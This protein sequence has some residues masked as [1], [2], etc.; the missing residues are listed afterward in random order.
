MKNHSAS[1]IRWLV[2]ALFIALAAPGR[3]GSIANNLLVHLSFDGNLADDSGS[4]NNGNALGKP[5]FAAGKIGSALSYTTLANGGS[6]NYVSLPATLKFG[7]TTNFTVAFWVNFT[8]NS[9]DLPFVANMDWSSAA[10]PGWAIAMQDNGSWQWNLSGG[11][12]ASS[13]VSYLDT[14]YLRDGNWHHLAVSFNRQANASAYVDGN[15]VNQTP[16]SASTGTI[17]TGF[18]INVGQDGTGAYTDE[19]TAQ[20][21]NAHLDDLGIWSRELSPIE[22]G[23][24]YLQGLNGVNITAIPD[25]A[26]PFLYQL[27]P[28]SASTNA[29][30]AGT[31]FASIEDGYLNAINT[32]SIQLSLD[33]VQAAASVQY[34]NGITTL[35]YQPP[36]LLAPLTSHFYSLAFSDNN[37]PP[38][39]YTTS[40]HF[41]VA[42]Y[43][44]LVL[45]NPVYLETFDEVQPGALPAGWSTQNYSDSDPNNPGSSLYDPQDATY[46]NWVV[47]SRSIV[48][49]LESAGTWEANSRLEVA[50]LQVVNGVLLTNLIET[51][52]IYAESDTRVGAAIQYLFSPDYNLTGLSNLFISYRS[53]YEQSDN[54][55]GAVE[56]STN[57]GA[58]WLP[59]VYM[60]D[61]TPQDN[62]IAYLTNGASVVIDAVTTLTNFNPAIP[63]YTDP[64]TGAQNGGYYGAFIGAPVSQG[65]APYISLRTNG[66]PVSSKKVE[67][68]PIP[69]ANGQAAVRFRFAQAGYTS[70][71]FGIDD[72]GINQS[73]PPAQS[74]PIT[75]ATPTIFGNFLTLSWSGGAPP[76]VLESKAQLGATNWV[77]LATVSST[78]ILVQLNGSNNFFRIAGQASP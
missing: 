66:D 32:N 42:A 30:P 77:Q 26:N 44:N 4:G 11:D 43:T 28:S 78:S 18:P 48:Q 13:P 45:T 54:N 70:Y 53:I 63:A 49:D 24:I 27:T 20:A 12:P 56:Y 57:Q 41:V 76:Y 39:V 55:I 40:I 36:A 21:I 35:Q 6:F 7:A 9:D 37:T 62:Q 47:I 34:T 51:N 58:S 60:L 68:F 19:G 38:D 2:A 46:M 3:A 61:G 22:V 14:S 72:F 1:P 64:V 65:L 73:A 10:N 25:T 52:F 50:P 59:I 71:Y 74:T 69:A 23:L 33:G 31:L 16:I 5:G 67:S 17:D 8:N 29:S 15:L 75:L